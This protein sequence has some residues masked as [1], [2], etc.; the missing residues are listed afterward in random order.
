MLSLSLDTLA[1]YPGLDPRPG[2]C[3][4]RRW[5][6]P[7]RLPSCSRRRRTATSEPL[8]QARSGVGSPDLD[9]IVPIVV[10]MRTLRADKKTSRGE[11]GQNSVELSRS[12]AWMFIPDAS[13]I[14][15]FGGRVAILRR[16]KSSMSSP[17]QG[18]GERVPLVAVQWSQHLLASQRPLRRWRGSCVVCRFP[19]LVVHGRPAP[20]TEVVR[21]PYGH[22]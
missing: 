17:A 6:S 16:R 2:V 7:A 21:L 20:Y 14:S 5:V 10:R 12:R 4:P 18:N 3:C 22:L 13:S 15:E 11:L 9:T 19:S 8:V 1:C